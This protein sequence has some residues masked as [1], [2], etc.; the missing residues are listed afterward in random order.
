MNQLQSDPKRKV[1][2]PSPAD[3]R[4]AS[5]VFQSLVD[6]FAVSDPYRAKLSDAV[7]I[8]IAKLRSEN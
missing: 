5:I 8:E 1:I 7:R 2:F 6:D 4:T 3:A